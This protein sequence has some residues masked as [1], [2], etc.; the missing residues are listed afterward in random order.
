MSCHGSEV[1]RFDGDPA[2][3][4]QN[5]ILKMYAEL[6]QKLDPYAKIVS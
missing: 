1:W 3:L 6:M 2:P 5:N 4:A